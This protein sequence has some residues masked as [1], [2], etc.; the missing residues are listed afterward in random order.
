MRYKLEVELGI[1]FMD[2]DN[3]VIGHIRS[4]F[5]VKNGTDYNM[6]DGRSLY[7][8]GDGSFVYKAV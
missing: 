5:I 8:M 1:V 2:R 4:M 3:N 6:L 7:K